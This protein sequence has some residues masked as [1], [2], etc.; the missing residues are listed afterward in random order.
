M[1]KL[2]LLKVIVQPVFVVDD[3]KE[4]TE[5]AAEPIVVQ[6]NDWPTYASTQFVEAFDAL[7]VQINTKVISPNVKIVPA[8]RAARRAKPKATARKAS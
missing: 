1:S 4:L 3:G 7:Q 5:T 2:R 6:P 8:N